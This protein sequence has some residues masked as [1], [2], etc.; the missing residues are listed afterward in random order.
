[1]CLC[2]CINI[3]MEEKTKYLEDLTVCL[4]FSS[5]VSQPPSQ[6]TWPLTKVIFTK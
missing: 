5:I 4:L 1:M 3:Y 6:V 2:I